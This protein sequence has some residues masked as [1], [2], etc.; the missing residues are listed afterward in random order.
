MEFPEVPVIDHHAH[1]FLKANPENEEDYWAY[2]SEGYAT[3]QNPRDIRSTLFFRRTLRDLG[4]LFQCLP[5]ERV[6]WEKRKPILPLDLF[7]KVLATT[8]IKE[9][10]LDDGFQEKDNCSLAQIAAIIP[11]K[12]V[13]RI[14]TVVEKALLACTCFTDFL[15]NLDENWQ[16][17]SKS[18]V[19]L[20]SII[21]YRSGLAI[22]PPDAV[23]AE[24]AFLQCKKAHIR[25]PKRESKALLEY[26]LFFFLE[27][28]LVERKPIQFHTGYGDRDI[29]LATANPVLLKPLLDSERYQKIPVVLLHAGYPY[30]KECGFLSSVYPQVYTDIGLA[31]P[32]LSIFGMEKA[33]SEL[34]ENSP[35]TKILYSSDAH[36]TPEWFFLAERWSKKII[37]K[38]LEESVQRHEI[39]FSF[40]IESYKNIFFQNART[41]YG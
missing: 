21:A 2:F 7:Q 26:C 36:F 27:K 18:I 16:N 10:Y 12:R 34:L 41:L 15:E 11:S 24:E 29:D 39:S 13:L 23:K 8:T 1:P 4:E 35:L 5:E 19:A 17:L 33:L 22:S 9:I 31:I 6:V 38:V 14:E 3:C 20:K 40:A 37:K 28:N 30:C 25:K 32:Y